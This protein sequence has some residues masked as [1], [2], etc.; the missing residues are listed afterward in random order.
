MAKG[1]VDCKRAAAAWVPA[2]GLV[3]GGFP[4]GPEV[5]DDIP[6]PDEL[7]YRRVVELV[8]RHTGIRLGEGKDYFVVGRLGP[9]YRELRCSSWTD[10]CARLEAGPGRDLLDGLIQA[11]VTKETLFF[12]DVHPFEALKERILPEVLG[13]QGRPAF[14]RLWSAGCSTG[15]EPYSIAMALWDALQGG[16]AGFEVW[17]TDI[18]LTSLAHA[19][20]GVYGPMELSRGLSPETRARFFDELPG[21][22]ARI[23]D[24]LRRKVRFEQLN[25]ASERPRRTGFHAVFCRNVAIYFDRKG[26]RRLY[27]SLGAS[28]LPGGYL[29]LGAAETLLP[30]LPGFET[31][32]F[33][34]CLLFQKV[35][36]EEDRAG[37]SDVGEL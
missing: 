19:Q 28:V 34:K 15:Q 31:V 23:R 21:E 20:A 12:R 1:P 6:T 18:C 27:Q 14:L 24:E 9:L 7:S 36:S 4:T 30:G 13:R 2:A 16:V 3:P 11:V 37:A 25:L 8:Y 32:Y 33:G 22:Q 17:A 5:A 10:L 29:I 26:K 35:W